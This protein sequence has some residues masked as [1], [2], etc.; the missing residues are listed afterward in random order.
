MTE[1][2]FEGAGERRLELSI[3]DRRQLLPAGGL[4]L[5]DAQVTER[6]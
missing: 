5:T 1:D 6:V 3:R 4:R 2:I